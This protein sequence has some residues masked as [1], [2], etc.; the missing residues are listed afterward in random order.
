M[1]NVKFAVGRIIMPALAML[2]LPGC[3]M[4]TT[5]VQE[6]SKTPQTV[7]VRD[8]GMSTNQILV[9]YQLNRT[10][11]AIVHYAAWDRDFLAR[12]GRHYGAIPG[13]PVGPWS[14]KDVEVIPITTDIRRLPTLLAAH[15][16]V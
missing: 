14:A 10:G 15:S 8:A 4:L 5:S 6:A 2:L 3:M 1:K 12:N 16:A 13:E 9:R 11:R 7:E